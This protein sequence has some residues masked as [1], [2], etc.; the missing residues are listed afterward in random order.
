MTLGRLHWI[1]LGR[2]EEGIAV[3]ERALECNPEAGYVHQQL[4]LLYSMLGQLDRAEREAQQAVALQESLKSGAEGL[5]MVG[6]FVRL[7]YVRY[8]QG[9]YEEAIHEYE[10]ERVW[11]AE[12]DH[13]LKERVLIEIG[14]KT[15]AALWRRGDRPGATRVFEETLRAF[16]A[17]QARG[18]IR[19]VH[20]LLSGLPARPA[21]GERRGD[22]ARRRGRRPAAGADPPPHCPRP[23]FRPASG[24]ARPASLARFAAG[25]KRTGQ[26]ERN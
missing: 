2:F 8:L 6:S 23:R 5:H 11:L 10:R 7:G 13:A 9:R 22:G 1:G 20:E 4:A 16:R 17:R 25:A 3:F 15:S 24:L 18:A 21:R 19:P 12:H 14:Q 26:V